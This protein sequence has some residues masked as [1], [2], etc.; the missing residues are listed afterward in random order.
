[1]RVAILFND[2]A[3]LARGETKDAI[4]A[5]AVVGVAQAVEQAV[6]ECGW[7]PV[8]I[9]A[10]PTAGALAAALQAAGA[11]VVF[12]LCEAWA[13]EARFEAAVAWLLE[14]LRL[15]YTGSPPLSLSLALHKHLAKELLAARAVP[16]PRGRVLVAGNEPIEAMPF[17]WIVKPAAEDASH[18]ISLDSVVGGEAAARAQA[19]LVIARYGG[20]ALVEEFVEGREFNVSILGADTL[21]LSEID[22]SGFPAGRPRLVTYE[23]KWVEESPEYRGTPPVE[24]GDLPPALEGR[25]RAVALAAFRALGV[26][27]YGRVDIRLHPDRGPLVLEV[28]PNPDLSPD[29]GFARAAQRAGL[30]YAGL[31]RRLVEAALGRAS[32]S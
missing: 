5:R 12:N 6:R 24:P 22:F 15:P 18:G 13:G 21:P 16:V 19:R 3:G 10:P 9:P 1:M 20:P 29:A 7:Q 2:D 23:A 31:V 30:S 4:A 26:R 8:A 11:D 27:D 28:N 14:M 25:I 17:P 32:R